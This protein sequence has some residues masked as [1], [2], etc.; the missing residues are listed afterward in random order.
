MIEEGNSPN[1]ERWKANEDALKNAVKARRKVVRRFAAYLGLGIGILFD[2]TISGNSFGGIIL[3]P[4]FMSGF[5]AL[6]STV[7]MAGIGL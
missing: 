7:L 2:F 5:C 4:V 6:A 1:Y 3:L